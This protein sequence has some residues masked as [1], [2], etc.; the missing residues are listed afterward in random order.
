MELS[1]LVRQVLPVHRLGESITMDAARASAP[2]AFVELPCGRCHYVQRGEQ[3][4]VVLLLH[5][6]LYHG[7]MWDDVIGPLSEHARCYVLDLMGWGYSSRNEAIDYDYALYARQVLEFMDALGIERAS[8]VGQSMGGG[9]AIR[10]AVEHRD[11]VERL[12]LV[13]PASLPNPLALTGRV[14]ALPGVGEVVMGLGGDR[15]TAEN[16]KQLW[17]HDPAHVTPAY[18]AR[19]TAPLKI[20]GSTWTVLNIL[21]RLDFGSQSEHVKLLART[22]VPILLVWGRE[23]RAVPFAVGLTM[24]EMLPKATFVVIPHAGHTPHEE[25]PAT[26]LAAAV[27]FLLGA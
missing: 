10:F 12:V 14:F 15:V 27:P 23:D 18:V 20:Q 9:T 17:F 7:M 8:L 24:R 22:D 21:R 6:F 1:D 26:F 11:R 19:V 4:P 16:L 5:G 25:D 3:G 2:G 13:D